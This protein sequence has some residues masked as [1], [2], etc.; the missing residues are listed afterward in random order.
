MAAT[1]AAEAVIW[2]T[3][4]GIGTTAADAGDEGCSVGSCFALS[5]ITRLRY[6]SGF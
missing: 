3:A 2:S 4:T 1:G 5:T 6:V